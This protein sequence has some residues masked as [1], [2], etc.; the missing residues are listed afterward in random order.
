VKCVFVVLLVVATASGVWADTASF[1]NGKIG[2]LPPEWIG[3]VTGSGHAKWTIEA[4]DSA[5]SKPQVLKQSGEGTF[6]WCVLKDVAFTNGSIEVRF[7]TVAGTEDQ[8]GGVVWRFQDRDNYYVCRA[9]ALEDNVRIYR[10][11]KGRRVQFAGVDTKVTNNEWHTLRVEFAAAH[12]KVLF[13]G[14][15]LFEADDKTFTHAG[16][17]GVWTKA[18]SV[19]EFDNFWFGK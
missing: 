5:P 6:L 13:N 12:F 11:V 10:V 2:E 16:Q 9:N 17:V 8:A 14:R 7:K 1:D 15:L 19:T 18:D 4:D 3:G